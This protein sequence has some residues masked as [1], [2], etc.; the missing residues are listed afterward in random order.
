VERFGVE[1]MRFVNSSVGRQLRLRGINARVV[2]TG[3][4]RVVDRVKKI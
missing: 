3:V 1:A 4:V 2:Q